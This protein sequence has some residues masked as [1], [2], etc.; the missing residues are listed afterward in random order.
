MVLVDALIKY[1]H[2]LIVYSKFLSLDVG[3]FG[4]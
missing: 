2:K 4:C 3:M 1:S